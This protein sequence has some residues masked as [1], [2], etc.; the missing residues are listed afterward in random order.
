M[1]S[2]IGYNSRHESKVMEDNAILAIKCKTK[3]M[4]CHGLLLFALPMKETNMYA[5]RAYLSHFLQ[6]MAS[7]ILSLQSAIACFVL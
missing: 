2:T 5:T 6:T 1:Y 4:E 3:L 7:S